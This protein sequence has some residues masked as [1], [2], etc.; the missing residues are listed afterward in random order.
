VSGLG[1]RMWRRHLVEMARAKKKTVPGI[2]LRDAR[3]LTEYDLWMQ[4]RVDSAISPPPED[5]NA[6]DHADD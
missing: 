3:L 1:K 6:D 2:R 5:A 4:S